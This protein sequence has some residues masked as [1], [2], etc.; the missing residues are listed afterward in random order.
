MITL[1]GKSHNEKL[2]EMIRWSLS[3]FQKGTRSHLLP[4]LVKTRDIET[5][6]ERLSGW[7]SE[8]GVNIIRIDCRDLYSH[9]DF[10]NY[11]RTLPTGNVI[12]FSH[13]TEI[14]AGS[15][16]KNIGWAINTCKDEPFFDKFDAKN[17]FVIATCRP[18]ELCENFTNTSVS[19]SA[20]SLFDY[21]ETDLTEMV[22]SDIEAFLESREE[23]FF[24][25]RDLQMHLALYLERSNN[26]DN[27]EVEYYVPK[28][29]LLPE[30]IWNSE[31]KVDIVV[32]KDDK[33]VPIE[34]KYK[35]KEI[36]N[37][38]L[39]RF[40]EECKGIQIVKN[41]AAQNISKYDFWKDVRRLEI[42]KKKFKNIHG[43]ICLFLTNDSSYQ[44]Q[45][46]ENA[47]CKNFSMAPFPCHGKEM[48][49]Q[50]DAPKSRPNFSLDSTYRTSWK[51]VSLIG[52]S[53]T[54]LNLSYTILT[55]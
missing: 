13:V 47:K 48:N 49:W 12:L 4:Q 18:R 2:D 26:Y 46:S 10:C 8:I 33:F 40:G 1:K 25:E 15:E 41:Q 53:N 32:C 7:C 23:I 54:I 14:P 24:N 36:N 5:F 37:G 21:K 42:L 52:L 3:S 55:I 17:S 29:E 28:S 16:Q 43:G 44:N 35:T 45:T 27:V 51:N 38:S 22:K 19:N 11:M 30:Y 6:E 31:M 9:S 34:L 39:Y 20:F 50:G